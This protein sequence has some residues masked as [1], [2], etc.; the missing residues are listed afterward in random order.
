MVPCFVTAW[1]H[2]ARFG[3]HIEVGLSGVSGPKFALSKDGKDNIVVNSI[4]INT[5]GVYG[6][7][8]K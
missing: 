8:Y 3:F 1:N 6:K 4:I 5:E 7:K 2:I